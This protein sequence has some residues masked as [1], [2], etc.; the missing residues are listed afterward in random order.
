MS[1]HQYFDRLL[2]IL[3]DYEEFTTSTFGIPNQLFTVIGGTAMGGIV[4]GPLGAVVGG[5]AG[6]TIPYFWPDAKTPIILVLRNLNNQ[7][8]DIIVSAVQVLVGGYSAALL[9]AFLKNPSQKKEL[10][11]LLRKTL[12]EFANKR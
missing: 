3:E 6:L 1:Q 4:G 9:G 8:K 7:Q 2:T 11:D 5:V 12:M 10:A